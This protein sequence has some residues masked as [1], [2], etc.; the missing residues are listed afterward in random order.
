MF[1]SKSMLGLI[2]RQQ[3]HFYDYQSDQFSHFRAFLTIKLGSHEMVPI[4]LEVVDYP[5]TNREALK[6]GNFLSPQNRTHRKPSRTNII[7][8]GYS[9]Y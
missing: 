6:R 1:S 9:G 3:Q 7:V 8:F 4:C 5:N 2:C